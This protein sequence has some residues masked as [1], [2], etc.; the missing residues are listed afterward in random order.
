MLF[1]LRDFRDASCVRAWSQ[2]RDI[3]SGMK[4]HSVEQ[5]ECSDA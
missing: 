3:E 4:N 5:R 2:D 1:G